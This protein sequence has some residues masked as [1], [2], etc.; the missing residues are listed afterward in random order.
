[1]LEKN[2]Y[3]KTASIQSKVIEKPY[4]KIFIPFKEKMEDILL[5]HNKNLE[6]Q[7]DNRGLKSDFVFLANS[8]SKQKKIIF[9]KEKD[10]IYN[11]YLK[12]FNENYFIKIDTTSYQSKFLI[13]PW[14]LTVHAT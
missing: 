5:K 2:Q 8:N 6:P 1:M 10:S 4:L 14:S 7:E 9:F 3:V 12:T 11:L 13:T